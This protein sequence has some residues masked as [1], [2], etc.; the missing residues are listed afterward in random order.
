MGGKG[1]LRD[2]RLV[3][4]YKD[5]PEYK[6]ITR[7]IDEQLLF[8]VNKLSKMKHGIALGSRMDHG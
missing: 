3:I 5:D 8:L 1:E 6:M 2:H 4:Q 7:S